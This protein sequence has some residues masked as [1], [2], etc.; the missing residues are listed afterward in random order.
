MARRREPARGLNLE[1]KVEKTA[2][3]S[4]RPRMDLP[5]QR[6]EL[7]RGQQRPSETEFV[8]VGVNEV[9][10]A[11]SPFGIAGHGSWLVSCCERTAVKCINIGDVEDYAFISPRRER[12]GPTC[13]PVQR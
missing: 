7:D 13:K 1:R 12:R 11:L 8:A 6:W 10:V 2:G 3:G 5:H 9:E 4:T